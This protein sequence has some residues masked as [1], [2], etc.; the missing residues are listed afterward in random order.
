M[1]A[2]LP[3]VTPRGVSHFQGRI[4]RRPFLELHKRRHR[5]SHK[6]RLALTS[7][8]TTTKQLTGSLNHFF[9]ND[10]NGL[11]VDGRQEYLNAPG[12]VGGSIK[13]A[14]NPFE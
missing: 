13:H 10:N 4:L 5:V 8:L 6:E 3:Q 12:I 14:T 1:W 11:I 9:F 2:Q 7:K